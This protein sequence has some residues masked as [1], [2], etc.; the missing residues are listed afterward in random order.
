ME[1]RQQWRR[2]FVWFC[3]IAYFVLALGDTLQSG[4]SATGNVWVNGADM[5]VRR[6][7]IYSL[8]GT[9]A[10]AGI[11]AEPMSRDR[12]S[13]SQGLILSTGTN[14]WVLGLGRFLVA[15]TI[16][17][18]TAAMFVPG[19]L[20]GCQMPGIP[21]EQIGPFVLSHYTNAL[22][23]YVLP[24]YLVTSALVF[25]VAARWQSQTA[26]FTVAV[27]ILA[28]WVLT[29]MLLGQD[30]LRH[31]VF[32]KYA[33]FDPYASIAAAEFT[34]GWTNL[35]KNTQFPPVAGL[36][37]IN[38]LL[39]CLAGVV[40]V[41]V[42][43]FSIP[44]RIA[45]PQVKKQRCKQ[46]PSQQKTDKSTEKT[47]EASHRQASLLSQIVQMMLW[48]L[49]AIWR[50]PG[51][52]LLLAF[53]AFSLW[54]SAESAVTH[55]FS[56]P[57]T[58]L[59]VHN[60]GFYFDKVLVLVIVWLAGDLMWREAACQVSELMDAQP[61]ADT[62][63]FAS[64]T[65]SLLLV[66]IVFW[67][68]S[69]IAGLIYQLAAGYFHFE[70]GLYLTDSFVFKAPYY[71][72]LAILAI[73]MQAIVRR[74]YVAIG[75]VLLVYV[76]EFLLDAL[77]WY[78]PIYRYGHVSFF[79]YSLMDGYGHFWRAH[80]WFLLYW[81]LGASLVWIAGL[82]CY[83]RGLSS[84]D[85]LA[86]IRQRIASPR[87]RYLA[88]TLA[89]LFLLVGLHIWN[90][91]TAQ[92]TWPLIDGDKQMA[93]VE[94]AFADQWRDVPQPRIV[95]I[96]G[97]LDLYPSRRSFH[98]SGEQTLENQNSQSIQ[99][100][101]VLG[102][103]GLTIESIDITAGAKQIAV[104]EPL[105]AREY[106][107]LAPLAAGERMT[108]KFVTSWNPPPGFAVHAKNDNINEV[109][110][111]E[112]VGNGTSLLNLQ[113]MPAVGY[114][115][116]VEH[117]P[118][119]KRRK[120]GLDAEWQPPTRDIGASQPHSTSHLGWV[121]SIDIVVRTD[122][123]QSAWHAGKLM[124]QWIE[125]DG[126]KGYHF[127]LDRPTRGWSEILTGRYEVKRFRQENLPDV[128]MVHDADHN[129]V[130][131][132]FAAAIQEAMS[133]FAD[134]YGPPPFEAFPLVEQS[135]HYNGMGARSGLGFSSEILGWKSDLKASGGEDLAKMSAH[136][137]GMSWFNDQIIPANV[138]GAKIIHAGLPYW[139][140]MLYLHQRRDVDLDRKLRL[141]AMM[142]MFRGRSAMI[143]EEVPFTKE[144]KNSTMLKRKGSILMIYLASLIGADELESI[145]AEFL[146]KW[147]YHPAPY[148][149]ATDF[150]SHLRDRIPPRYHPQLED[151]F[152]HVTTW[153]L[154]TVQAK[155]QP[156]D[157]GQW[158]LTA[159]VDAVKLRTTGWGE[160]TD[161]PLET[162]VSIVA[163]N[164]YQFAESNIIE[165][166]TENLPGGRS[167][168]TML[169]DEKP[170]RFG[171]DP[172]LSLPDR[173]PHDNVKV[174]ELNSR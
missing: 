32:T 16:V 17:L 78:H 18:L 4:L 71:L 1:W 151:I 14:R 10:V 155:C 166:R 57:S 106:Q 48:E 15:F 133:H 118:T 114:T 22:L 77:G 119:W 30:I 46:K 137:M 152:E 113:L 99:R 115:D 120:L 110:P 90:Q 130:V 94:Q 68:V 121:E 73:A 27:G 153:R 132:E 112:L 11:V 117:K 84:S 9:L 100:L 12:S 101:L 143:D 64:K 170:T 80:L 43:V 128:V 141:Q 161:V 31:E 20:L 51:A 66:V 104:N 89:S 122:S 33:V 72:W 88:M 140:A 61:T 105:N 42:G 54:W 69:I 96:Q 86:L 129:Y 136:M 139:S 150:L 29:R 93:S 169:L 116:R 47:L 59:L 8:L 91:S 35:Q 98:F 92:A 102:E 107:L 5:I 40:L 60:T 148:P 13:G 85:R 146:E 149:T 75:V 53:T 34:Q 125:P 147:R 2:P 28:L 58:D 167:E 23:Y 164:G 171:I 157:D 158:Q 39:W 131:D 126:R 95:A 123:D 37:L 67:S 81:T 97:T 45:L 83:G 52:K 70:I 154:K 109:M 82:W 3:L 156:T 74:R 124:R 26:A 165:Q 19:V 36:M 127:A 172:Y 145:F 24:N 108:L 174:V 160:Q 6:A 55:Q 135:L 173:N 162:P 103:P 138:E 79:W 62:A 38:R 56:L 7:L 159:N 168:I 25:A 142:E 50:T 21:Q 44:L 65:L 163:F 76:S 144:M 49:R 41:V 134:R 111:V 87:D 63:R